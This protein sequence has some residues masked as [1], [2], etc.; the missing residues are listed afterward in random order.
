M[1][2]SIAAKSTMTSQSR[3][4]KDA[5]Y[6]AI[7][8]LAFNDL[9]PSRSTSRP[10]VS[11]EPRFLPLAQ[12]QRGLWFGEKLDPRTRYIIL[13]NTAKFSATLIP[14]FSSQP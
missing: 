4:G 8:A 12:S 10:L 14:L 11:P 13:L 9:K 2:E 5:N 6:V 7:D 1:T 3:S